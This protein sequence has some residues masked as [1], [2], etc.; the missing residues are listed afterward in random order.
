MT[1]RGEQETRQAR[2]DRDYFGKVSPFLGSRNVF[3]KPWPRNSH[4]AVAAADNHGD[5]DAFGMA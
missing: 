4:G 2:L 5:P 1:M 3:L